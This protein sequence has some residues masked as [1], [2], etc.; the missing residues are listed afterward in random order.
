MIHISKSIKIGLVSM[1][2]L[3]L[4]GCFDDV[5]YLDQ[6]WNDDNQFRTLSY[7]TSQGS[8]LIPYDWYL[9]LTD[10]QTGLPLNSP[11]ITERLGYLPDYHPDETTNPDALPIGF[12]K[13][14]D[15]KTG[16][17]IG[18]NCA[19]CHTGQVLVG[20]TAIRIDGAPGLGDYIGLMETTKA[21]IDATLEN[22]R[23][24]KKFAKKLNATDE[25]TLRSQLSLASEDI[26]GIIYR[27]GSELHQG[28]FGRVDAA[29]AIRNE[30][31]VHDL[32]IEENF[33]VP[34][35]PVSYPAL[36]DTPRF[37]KVQYPGYAENP[38]GRNVGQVLGVLGRLELKDPATFLESSVRREN[39]FYLEQWLYQLQA[40][41]WPESYLGSI[42]QVAAE[43]GES[44]YK[45]A[46]ANGYSC[47]GCHALKD[48]N[49]QY[50]MTPREQNAFGLQFIETPL[51][52]LSVV[53][54][55]PNVLL[56]FY[57]PTPIKTAQLAPLLGNQTEVPFPV[58]LI[59]L[60][61]YSVGKLFYAD[62]ELTPFEQAA[63][64]GYRVYAE[65]Y[66]QRPLV[67][68]Y[69]TRPLAGV[70]ATSPYLHNG[71]VPNLYELLLPADE[72]SDSF[73]VGSQR[74]DT[75]NVGYQT[76]R[77]VRAFEFDTSVS[78]NS[79]SGHEFST[80]LTDA[81]RYDLVEYLKTL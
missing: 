12:V 24:F 27:N 55:D 74:F 18:V 17:W 56:N 33:A 54:T 20:D 50:P 71:S 44:L 34:S 59:S 60:T 70:W 14:S 46:D 66:E 35:A 4:T 64:S 32:G 39:V 37:D 7:A 11:V 53:Q 62:P 6:N 19:A 13:D 75:E 42:D 1:M 41:Q 79:N 29:T 31:F 68:G 51:T 30:I 3:N 78:G 77:D 28:G 47:V 26:A 43:R 67:P 2:A 25:E 81:E 40:P 5:V 57:D 49:G 63:Y 73:Y 61:A 9:N 80:H 48:E 15:P 23:S 36:W 16:D 72:R 38:F 52:P 8:Q 45:T 65:G 69:L 76:Q 10:A 21:A 22:T 58:A